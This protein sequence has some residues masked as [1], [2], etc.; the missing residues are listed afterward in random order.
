MLNVT[1]VDPNIDEY[2][3]QFAMSHDDITTGDYANYAQLTYASSMRVEDDAFSKMVDSYM[4]NNEKIT[5]ALTYE[6]SD[7]AIVRAVAL[8]KRY[9]TAN[10]LVRLNIDTLYAKVSKKVL[11]ESYKLSRLFPFGFRSGAGYGKKSTD[12]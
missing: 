1:V 12:L 2:K 11:A 10:I 6:M 4:A 7:D 9:K 5:I 8:A 3:N